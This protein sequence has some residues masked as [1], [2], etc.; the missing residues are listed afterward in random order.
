MPGGCCMCLFC[1]FATLFFSHSFS[2]AENGK[3]FSEKDEFGKLTATPAKVVKRY[4]LSKQH[5]GSGGVT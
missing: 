3:I 5:V 1:V 4:V 2:I